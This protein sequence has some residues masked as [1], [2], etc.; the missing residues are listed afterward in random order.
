M[1]QGDPLSSVELPTETTNF[2]RYR[3]LL[4]NRNFLLWFTSAMTSSLGDWAGLF[5]LQSLVASLSQ[6]GSRVQLFSLGAIMMART[7][8]S[9]LLGP[10]AGVFAD[11][12]DR[13]RLMVV[14]DIVRAAMF[15]VIAFTGDL[16]ALFALTFIVESMS[17]LFASAK[18]ATLATLVDR[19]D[20]TEANQLNLI[21]TYG[22]L[23]LGGLMGVLLAA[24]SNAL[25]ETALEATSLV[26]LLNAGTFL[27]SAVLMGRLSVSPSGRRAR[28]EE[29]AGIVAELR[30]GLSF[31]RNMPVVRA[32]IF[33]VV[34]I[35]FGGGV[36][37][38]L[39]PALLEDSDRWYTVVTLVGAG[40]VLGMVL[41]A[42]LAT[43]FSKERLLGVA[44]TVTAAIACGIAVASGFTMILLLAFF[45]G[46]AAGLAFVLGYTLLHEQTY[47][48]TETRGTTFATFYTG[49]RAAMF[50]ALGAAPLVA[51]AIGRFSLSFGTVNVSLSG[52]RITILSGGLLGLYAAFTTTRALWRRMGDDD[53]AV[54]RTIAPRERGGG[55]GLFIAFEGVEGAGKSTQITKLAATLEAEGRDVVITR[56]PG[57]H[58][59]AERV[60][61]LLLDPECADMSARAEALLYSA[62]RAQLVDSVIQPALDAGRIVLS[63]RFVDSS[64]AYQAYGRALGHHEILEINQWATAGL[65][66]DV[67]V[68]LK[69]DPGKGLNRVDARHS[70]QA[71]DE[72]QADGGRDGPVG[73]DRLV[74]R[75]RME[76]QTAEFHEAVASAYTEL[77]RTAKRR[78]VTIEADT[79]PESVAR[80]VRIALEE[81]LP[82]DSPSETTSNG[83]ASESEEQESSRHGSAGPRAPAERGGP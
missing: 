47:A 4:G 60:R 6:Q 9:L 7:L 68:W 37:F 2:S 25:R 74:G 59:V 75:D 20:L 55:K 11:R 51:G 53:T 31:I 71:G 36:I 82:R 15:V 73:R 42:V 35:F 10:V 67:V 39:G 38:A 70:G 3:R 72:D 33:G 81:W 56:E 17:L 49:T 52:L 23:P 65:R 16:V 79:D 32:L 50:L 22:T 18:D 1:S 83:N 63:D 64:L 27:V 8:P 44:M 61:E 69:I 77:A 41:S 13:K 14:T 62:A 29:A 66:P 34:G 24:L 5:A 28:H 48:D 46:A 40:L 43:R 78:W 54:G 45:L 12:Y 19:D 58:P 30:E 21:V 80:D 26:L 76:R 57:G